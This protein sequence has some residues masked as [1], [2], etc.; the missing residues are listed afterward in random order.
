MSFILVFIP[1]KN[2]EQIQVGKPMCSM[3]P[4]IADLSYPC[5][6]NLLKYNATTMLDGTNVQKQKPVE[7]WNVYWAV[8]L[9]NKSEAKC[10]GSCP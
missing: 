2:K 3:P 1:P 7:T 10:G 4:F 9:R 5:L 6:D 8:A